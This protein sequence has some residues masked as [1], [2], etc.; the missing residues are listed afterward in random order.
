MILIILIL[1][2]MELNQT[3]SSQSY[4]IKTA[5]GEP[6]YLSRRRTFLL[7]FI[8]TSKAV[9]LLAKDRLLSDKAGLKY[10][11]TFCMHITGP[12]RG[13]H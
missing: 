1:N 10:L 13:F 3:L 8:C 2:P 4:P 5:S 12:P 11:L 7:G 6:L 9:G